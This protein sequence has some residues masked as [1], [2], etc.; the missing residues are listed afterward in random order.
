VSELAARLLRWFESNGRH[1]L[2]WQKDASAY[3]I[4]ISEV[5]LQQTQVATVIPYYERFIRRFPDVPAL[6]AGELDDVLAHWSGLGYYARARNLHKAARIVEQTLGGVIPDSI[7]SLETLPGIGRSTAAAILALSSGQ[8]HA[9]L[10]GNVKRVLA[11]FHAVEGW[12]GRPAVS[13]EL[14]RLAESHTPQDRVAAYTQAIMDLGAT[15]CRRA[16]PH[17][18]ACPVRA[19]CAARISDR[20]AEF[21]ARRPRRARPRRTTSMLVIRDGTGA[22]LLEKRPAAGLW[23]GLYSFPEIDAAGSADDWCARHLGASVADA[24]LLDV[25]E[26]S[27]THFDL[28]IRPVSIRIV[29]TPRAV[30]DRPEWLWYKPD[31]CG[32]VG[33]PAPIAALLDAVQ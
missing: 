7:E 28:D 6:A 30:M 21:P 13:K 8:R 9:I 1:D 18:E 11:R 12:P 15:V 10:D 32:A 24:E 22:V 29:D 23:G 3:S 27:F 14:W 31:A 20:V 16:N 4:W 33:M 25:V 2:P 17:C 26:H 5:M 19:D